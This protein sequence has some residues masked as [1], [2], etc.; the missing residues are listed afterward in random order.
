MS[1]GEL[2]N[3]VGK[4]RHP[5]FDELFCAEALR[6]LNHPRPDQPRAAS[7]AGGGGEEPAPGAGFHDVS[8]S[9]ADRAER[10]VADLGGDA[11][12]ASR[13]AIRARV[14]A[15]GD[16]QAVAAFTS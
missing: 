2:E 5:H 14:L 6:L 4:A 15:D 8:G 10:A 12:E 13:D 1:A 11:D 16:R 9:A 3:L 7:G